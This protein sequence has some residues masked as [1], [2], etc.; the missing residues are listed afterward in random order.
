MKQIVSIKET[1]KYH[2]YKYKDK[3][4]NNSEEL[5]GAVAIF[6]ESQKSME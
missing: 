6:N 5:K 2:F 4:Y 1:C 3:I